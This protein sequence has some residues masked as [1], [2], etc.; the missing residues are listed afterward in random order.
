MY[1]FLANEFSSRI[2]ISASSKRPFANEF[3]LIELENSMNEQF[4]LQQ[5]VQD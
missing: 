2:L 3:T 4:L 5:F 1:C